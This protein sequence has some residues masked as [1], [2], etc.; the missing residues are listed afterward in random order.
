MTALLRLEA[1]VAFA[2]L[3]RILTHPSRRALWF[4]TGALAATAIAFDVATSDVASRDLGRWTPSP[5][6]VAAV[7]AGVLAF[8]A[9]VGRRTPL[10]YGTRAADTVW[11]HYAGIDAGAGQRATTAILTLRATALIAL[12]AV[13]IGALLALAAP[14]RAGAIVALAAIV[15][16]LAPATVLVSSACAPRTVADGARTSRSG[17]RTTEALD[18]GAAPAAE[19]SRTEIPHGLMAARWLVAVR[20]GETLV[21]YDRFAFG[22]VAG[23]VA[24]RV[25]AVAG[26]QLI[27]MAIVIGG[28]AVLLDASIRGTTAPATLRSPWWRAAIGASPPALATWAFSDA[29]GTASLLAGL[30]LGLGIALGN[31]APAFAALPAILLVPTALRLVVLAVDTSYPA[32][33]DR[34][35]AGATV[36]LVVVWQLTIAIFALAVVTGARGGAYASIA[37]TTAALCVV[38][39]A[40]AWYGAARLPSAV[41]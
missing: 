40:A 28:L 41:D 19:R 38:V 9:L 24:P 31:P 18:D 16:V 13:P 39:A 10:T 22:V 21:P 37:A 26:G 5:L 8:A 23:F 2:A 25:S 29:A 27:A 7:A 11:W 3:R 35:G 34:R 32:A 20:R 1:R 12:G 4:V 30:A 6:L 17:A 14:Q 33:V 36:R 15:I